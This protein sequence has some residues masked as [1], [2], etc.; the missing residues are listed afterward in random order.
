MKTAAR[1]VA[2]VM[3]CLTLIAFSGALLSRNAHIDDPVPVPS[4][5]TAMHHQS[6]I[7]YCQLL[8]DVWQDAADGCEDGSIKTV[9]DYHDAV[10]GKL[11]AVAR[12]AFE[13]CA[14]RQNEYLGPDEDGDSQWTAERGAKWAEQAASGLRQVK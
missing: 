8:A 10:D 9:K 2:A 3:A 4:D 12:A 6:G 1:F 11:T 7:E 5:V 13:D 14:Q